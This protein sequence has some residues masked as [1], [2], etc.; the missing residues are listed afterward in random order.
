MKYCPGGSYILM[1]INKIVTGYIAIM[2]IRYKKNS[3][4]VLEY[5]ENEGGG[6]T[7]TYDIYLFIF[8]EIY[9]NV[10]IYFFK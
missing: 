8:P 2:T 4:K 7:D 3:H 6:S 1:N 5:I 9:C 10:Y